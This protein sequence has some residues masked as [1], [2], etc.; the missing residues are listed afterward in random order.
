M[1]IIF[2]L[3]REEKWR[4]EG[5]C[6]NV[7]A[8]SGSRGS[9]LCIVFRLFFDMMFASGWIPYVYFIVYLLFT[10]F[11]YVVIGYFLCFFLFLLLLRLTMLFFAV[12]LSGISISR[13][14]LG[15]CILG[16]CCGI[17]VIYESYHFLGAPKEGM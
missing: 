14:V 12:E 5:F 8:L 1:Y 11:G 10:S 15:Y 3:A 13:Y 6:A 2:T 7:R 9:F 16:R 17:L 4:S